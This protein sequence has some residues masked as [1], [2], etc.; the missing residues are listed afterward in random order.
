[1]PI[2]EE[3][4]LLDSAARAKGGAYE[5]QETADGSRQVKVVNEG[6]V[7]TRYK[8]P[9]GH[10]RCFASAR[11]ENIDWRGAWELGGGV[12]IVRGRLRM[13]TFH[14]RM[15]RCTMVAR[16]SLRQ[17][18]RRM[19]MR[20]LA[21]AAAL[22]LAFTVAFAATPHQG[23]NLHAQVGVPCACNWLAGNQGDFNVPCLGTSNMDSVSC[24]QIGSQCFIGGY[25]TWKP[26][27]LNCLYAG[28]TMGWIKAASYGSGGPSYFN[29][30]W[31]LTKQSVPW[32]VLS[33]DCSGST[34]GAQM[35]VAHDSWT[36][37]SACTCTSST[38]TITTV[39]V[40]LWT[41]DS[42]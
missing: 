11:F 35:Q 26:D 18:P 8:G 22:A 6:G 7:R 21:S 25:A 14:E 13:H 36:G 29:P 31:P 2:R 1:M 28:S 24:T 5:I 4:R 37:G 38:P 15:R 17:Q 3:Y 27:A 20:R 32:G 16:H 19:T 42:I 23:S 40:V 41:C 10:R 12:G 33:A 34:F 30:A 9:D 39:A